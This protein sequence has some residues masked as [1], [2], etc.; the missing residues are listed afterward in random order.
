MNIEYINKFYKSK[1]WKDWADERIIRMRTQ[2]KICT[3]CGDEKLLEEFNKAK[4]GKYGV[5]ALCRECKSIYNKL[6]YKNN[7]Q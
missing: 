5:G 1:I 3:E 7:L 6:R 4:S 2:N